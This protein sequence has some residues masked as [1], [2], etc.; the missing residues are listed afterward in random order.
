[1]KNKS[2]T[3]RFV[4]SNVY[5]VLLLFIL[6]FATN[7]IAQ[8]SGVLHLEIPEEKRNSTITCNY[9]VRWTIE[10]SWVTNAK[11][12]IPTW[13][14]DQSEFSEIEGDIRKANLKLEIV[15]K[16][17]FQKMIDIKAPSSKDT[18]SYTPADITLAS[19]QAEIECENIDPTFSVIGNYKNPER[20]L[21]DGKP[22]ET[23]FTLYPDQNNNVR[24]VNLGEG[25]STQNKELVIYLRALQ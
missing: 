1:M 18:E 2:C 12:Q 14:A 6:S 10:Y 5:V 3:T 20:L 16:G 9:E 7:A 17:Y 23:K 8:E 19:S 25:T 22:K 13:I 4:K 21:D 15:K 24:R 11:T